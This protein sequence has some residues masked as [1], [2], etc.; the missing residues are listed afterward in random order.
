[1]V[2]HTGQVTY[3]SASDENDRVLL[4]VVSDTG[5]VGG[6]IQAVGQSYSCDLTKRGVRLLR[7]GGG[8]LCANASLLGGRLVGGNIV[9]R[10]KALLKNAAIDQ[11]APQKRGVCTKV[12]TTSP[13]KPN[14]AM[15]KIARVRLTNGLEATVYIP[16]IG[17]NLQEHS[18]VLIRGGRVR[19][20]PG[21]RYHIIRGSLDAQ[22]VANRNQSRSKYGAKRAKKK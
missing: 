22:G 21:V 7:A 20:L 17:H 4:K 5:N 19:D 11:S 2:T 1:M 18:V 3:T 14:S 15:R 13:K 6:C 16:G 10:V 8:Y 9:Q 12:S